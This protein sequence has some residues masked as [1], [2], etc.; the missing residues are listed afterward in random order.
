MI[1]GRR[2][3]TG[4]DPRTIGTCSTF[5]LVDPLINPPL[6]TVLFITWIFAF[7]ESVDIPNFRYIYIYVCN[8]HKR[9]FCSITI[10][11]VLYNMYVYIYLSYEIR[12]YSPFY[13]SMEFYFIFDTQFFLHTCIFTLKCW[14][15][16][17]KMDII[18]VYRKI[19]CFIP[20]RSYIV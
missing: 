15:N 4:L 7:R 16:F 19:H 17:L 1:E 6:D 13:F 14:F 18:Y 10:V 3:E 2:E 11:I 12:K 9:V 8:L 5:F 20:C